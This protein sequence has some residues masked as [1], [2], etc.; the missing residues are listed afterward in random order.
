MLKRYLAIDLRGYPNEMYEEV[1]TPERITSPE[2]G[3]AIEICLD[4]LSEIKRILRELGKTKLIFVRG[5][6]LKLN[7]GK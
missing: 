6:D 3:E 5:G 4:D 1:Y 2:E 7:R